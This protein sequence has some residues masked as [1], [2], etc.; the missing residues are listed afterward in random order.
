[1]L[2]RI[3]DLTDFLSTKGFYRLRDYPIL[4]VPFEDTT[5]VND[6]TGVEIDLY[7]NTELVSLNDIASL[8]SQQPGGVALWQELVVW[9][10]SKGLIVE[11]E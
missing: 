5:W 2:I 7:E 1:M 6:A 10:Q 8:W 3:T 9:A 11:P 4:D